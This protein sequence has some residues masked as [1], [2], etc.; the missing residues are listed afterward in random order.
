VTGDEESVLVGKRGDGRGEE[1]LGG[2][3]PPLPTSVKETSPYIHEEPHEPCTSPLQTDIP[4]S[5]TPPP[6]LPSPPREA[7]YLVATNAASDIAS[8]QLSAQH[9]KNQHA[10]EL[11]GLTPNDIEVPQSNEQVT[12]DGSSNVSVIS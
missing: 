10:T 11:H 12:I 7:G 3:E 9:I 5:L 1:A 2:P 4:L 6:T 8:V